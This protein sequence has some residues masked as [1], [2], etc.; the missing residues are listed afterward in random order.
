MSGCDQKARA[1]GAL[2]AIGDIGQDQGLLV[3]GRDERAPVGRE[4]EQAAES[5]IVEG[6]EGC[7]IGN[8]QQGGAALRQDCQALAVVRPYQPPRAGEGGLPGRLEQG[9]G[10]G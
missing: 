3:A 2:D 6:E 10:R 8:A 9:G 4:V 1:E 7:Q 5:R